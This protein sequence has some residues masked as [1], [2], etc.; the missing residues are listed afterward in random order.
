MTPWT[1][2]GQAP[3]SLGFSRQEYWSG[4][5]C[6]SP[7]DLPYPGI[8]PTS[9]A[10]QANFLPLSYQEAQQEC[11]LVTQLCPALCD[12]MDCSLP[13]SSVHG[14]LQARL[15]E[16]VAMPSSR[17]SSPP[18]P[19]QGSN[20]RLLCLL[21]WQEGSLPLVPPGKPRCFSTNIH[22]FTI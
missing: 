9:P 14:I 1:V 4:L 2:A 5:P 17:G 15:L 11:V 6:P 20:P 10:L 19:H 16:W 18:P 13:G 3:L 12:P 22:L 21:H 8:Y 7:G